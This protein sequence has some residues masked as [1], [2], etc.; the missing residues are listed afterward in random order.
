LTIANIKEEDIGA[1]VLSV[2]NK[3]GKVD[4]TSNVKVTAPLNFSKPLDDLNIIQGSNGV[5]SVDCGGVPK[6]K[7]T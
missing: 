5:L 3:L 7:L 1:Y 4:T 2:K 6:P